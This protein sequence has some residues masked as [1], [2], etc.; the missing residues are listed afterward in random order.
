MTRSVK[1]VLGPQVVNTTMEATIQVVPTEDE[2]I[3]LRSEWDRILHKDP[4][5]TVF[6]SWEWAFWSWSFRSWLTV[7]GGLHG[8]ISL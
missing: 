1:D 6:Q 5:G 8:V 7:G 3:K 4:Y 2:F